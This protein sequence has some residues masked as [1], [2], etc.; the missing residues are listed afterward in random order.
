MNIFEIYMQLSVQY[1]ILCFNAIKVFPKNGK[2]AHRYFLEFSKEKRKQLTG[3]I[4][5]RERDTNQYTDQYKEI[6]KDFYLNLSE[7]KL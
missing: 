7:G 2:D 1:K 3:N 4:S 5:I 6:T